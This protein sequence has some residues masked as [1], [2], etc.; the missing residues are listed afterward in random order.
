[1]KCVMMVV[2]GVCC[3]CWDDIVV[4]KVCTRAEWVRWSDL[5]I[6]DL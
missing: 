6:F 4:T 2:V 1:M 3:S 5:Y